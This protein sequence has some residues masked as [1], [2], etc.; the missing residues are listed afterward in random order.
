[1][2]SVWS[3]GPSLC[4]KST[5]V[6]KVSEVSSVLSSLSTQPVYGPNGKILKHKVKMVDATFADGTPQSLYFDASHKKAGVFK[7]MAVILEEWGLVKESQLRAECKKFQCPKPSGPNGMAQC[8]CRRVLY[9]Q[10]DFREV[11]SLL[12]TTCKAHGFEVLFLPKFHCELNFIEQCWGSQKTSTAITQHL[13]KK[14]I[15]RTTFL[16]LWN[17]FH[18]KICVGMA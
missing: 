7:G 12:E 8:C 2:K 4:G 9:N 5:K 6:S 13:L 16:Q 10:P 15:W 18:L 17:P 14:L 3:Q 11:E 1:M